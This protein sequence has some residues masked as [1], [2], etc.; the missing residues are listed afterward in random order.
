MQ[1]I[2]FDSHKRYT[3]ASVEDQQSGKIFDKRINHER[4]ALKEFLSGCE[5][6]SPVAV[7]TIGNWY[8]IVDEIEASGMQPRLVHA[9]KAKLMLS[10]SKK[11]DKLDAHGMN[12]LQRTGTLPTVWIPNSQLRDIRELFRTRMVLSRQRTRIKNRIHSSLSKYGISIDNTSD[13]FNLKGRNAIQNILSYLPEHTRFATV[14]LLEELDFIQEK[15]LLFQNRMAE[16]FSDSK[17]VH[18]LQTLPGVGPILSVVIASEIGDVSRF[19]TASHLAAYSG[20]TPRIHASGGK[21]RYGR[22]PADTNRYL[23]WAFAEAANVVVKVR[24]KLKFRHVS[25]LYERIR[26]KK[27]HSVAIGA[28]SRHLAEAAYWVLTKSEP[29]REPQKNKA[30][31]S[32]NR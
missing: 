11:T 17:E 3:F 20:T 32:T 5:A 8:W 16:A 6:G 31:S 30:I 2:A 10:S 14:K 18:L 4:G 9:R 21:Y 7:E 26:V 23:K 25:E 13:I 12:R 15:I 22:A 28:V 29:Y 19:P 1:Y 24:R 27:G